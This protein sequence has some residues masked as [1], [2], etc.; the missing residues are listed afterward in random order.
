MPRVGGAA[1]AR[2]EDDHGVAVAHQVDAF[3]LCGQVKAQGGQLG[4]HPPR[5]LLR[6]SGEQLDAAGYWQRPVGGQ[7]RARAVAGW[8][9]RRCPRAR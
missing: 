4:Q 6:P 8:S 7:Q 5:R 9:A 2:R 3:E 1:Q